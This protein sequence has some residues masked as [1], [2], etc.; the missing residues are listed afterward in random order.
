MGWFSPII[1]NRGPIIA[2]VEMKVITSLPKLISWDETSRE[3]RLHKKSMDTVQTDRIYLGLLVDEEQ[4]LYIKMYKE[5]DAIIF[6][7]SLNTITLSDTPLVSKALFDL[8]DNKFMDGKPT[9]V[10]NQ[11]QENNITVVSVE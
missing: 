11:L 8:K 7:F 10:I 1:W 3:L 2:S 9:K 6:G 4:G 5:Y